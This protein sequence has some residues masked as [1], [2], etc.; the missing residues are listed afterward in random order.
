MNRE[1]RQKL[2]VKLKELNQHH[3]RCMYVNIT[4]FEC[5]DDIRD[6]A[7]QSGTLFKLA[8]TNT[9]GNI[10]FADPTVLFSMSPDTLKLASA[11]L[12]LEGKAAGK[13]LAV[14]NL[15]PGNNGVVI[16]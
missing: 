12:E 8:N 1:A 2:I 6:V 3:G 13:R 11:E 9:L 14:I 4:M 10:L 5:L 15:S 16:P 7:K